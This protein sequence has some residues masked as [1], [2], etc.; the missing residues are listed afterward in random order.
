MN[1]SRIEMVARWVLGLTFIY[2]SYH[3]II[4]PAQ[5]AKGCVQTSLPLGGDVV[6]VGVFV[7]LDSAVLRIQV[8]THRLGGSPP[9][10]GPQGSA[11]TSST[12]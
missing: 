6:G 7:M 1:S 12:R 11:A 8:F 4:A 3:K 9:T 2:A 10:R 5:F